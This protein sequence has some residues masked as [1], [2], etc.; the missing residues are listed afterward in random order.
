[1]NTLNSFK[2]YIDEYDNNVGDQLEGVSS[3]Y[4][5][6]HDIKLSMKYGEEEVDITDFVSLHWH[7]SSILNK[8]VF[9]MFAPNADKDAE[10]T[11]EEMTKLISMDEDAEKLGQFMVVITDAEE[12]FIRFR[13]AAE[14]LGYAVKGGLIEYRDFSNPISLKDEEIGFVKRIEYSHQQEYR[15]MVNT[16]KNIDEHVDMEIGPLDDITILIA[17]KDFNKK[18]K[19]ESSD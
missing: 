17:T 11:I 14:R 9:C 18:F 7:E 1:M 8:N 15:L 19:I 5:G 13:R 16:G 4:L 3:H 6:N 10:F 12:F 2:N